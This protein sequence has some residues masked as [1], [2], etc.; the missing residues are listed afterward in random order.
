M[1]RCFPIKKFYHELA[2][3]KEKQFKFMKMLT[4]FNFYAC[5]HALSIKM[6]PAAQQEGK[7]RVE[8]T[9]SLQE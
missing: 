1:N 3:E 5:L 8:A 4:L 2:I 9:E 7:Q 6:I